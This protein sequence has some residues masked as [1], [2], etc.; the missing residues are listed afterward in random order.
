MN[1]SSISV[2]PAGERRNVVSRVHEIAS[3]N[4]WV[5]AAPTDKSLF[6][7]KLENGELKSTKL[8]VSPTVNT[9][10]RNTS[11]I[12]DLAIYAVDN[13]VQCK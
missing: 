4:N 3:W 10:E 11:R 6:L 12:L 8:V 7:I 9:T 2:N 5:V 13:T 1:K